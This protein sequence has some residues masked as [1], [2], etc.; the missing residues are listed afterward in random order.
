M[1]NTLGLFKLIGF[2]IALS[3][4]VA[5]SCELGHAFKFV[6]CLNPVILKILLN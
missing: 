1:L 5:A 3:K 2:K 6:A 4:I